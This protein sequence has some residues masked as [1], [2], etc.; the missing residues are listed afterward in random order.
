[1]EILSNPVEAEYLSKASKTDQAFLRFLY[2]QNTFFCEVR[3]NED[4]YFALIDSAIIANTKFSE[5]KFMPV[6]RLY[7]IYM[8]HE[9][10]KRLTDES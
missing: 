4:G 3:K 10:A 1:M 7:L 2:S 6:S 5:S 9:D 8:S